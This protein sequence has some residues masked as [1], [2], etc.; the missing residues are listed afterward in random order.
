MRL[1]LSAL[2]AF[3]AAVLPAEAAEPLRASGWVRTSGS[4]VRL[5]LPDSIPATGVSYG[6]LEVRLQPGAKTYWRSPGD[7]GVPPM[8]DF[9][10]S[11]GLDAPQLEFPAPVAFDDGAGGLAYGY[12]EGLMFP[13]RLRAT[14]AS[15]TAKLAVT[16]SYGVCLKALCM[17]AE[18]TLSLSSGEGE[19]D[20]S[21]AV[22][23]ATALAQVPRPV[24]LGSA[25]PTAIL[26]VTPQ[27][28]GDDLT[29][30][31]IARIPAGE[32]AP[33]LFVEGD[34]SF[35]TR[36]EGV[37]DGGMARFTAMTTLGSS[38]DRKTAALRLTLVTRRTAIE[39]NLDLD[40]PAKQ[41]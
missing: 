17:P 22:R 4:A 1:C 23:L 32:P 15:A 31:I 24:A 8:A 26:T 2:V 3:L 25:E 41:P 7:T 39:S 11:Q 16:F 37:D 36:L 35:Q 13:I 20:P 10:Q 40:V 18:A 19:A 28:S 12:T 21:L 33:R 27:R 34:D 29:L 30:A 6:G 5:I 38:T 9:S 14:S